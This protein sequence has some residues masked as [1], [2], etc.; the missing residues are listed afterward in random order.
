MDGCVRV[1]VSASNIRAKVKKFAPHF[2]LLNNLFD[3]ISRIR[4][5]NMDRKS[6]REC[7]V[8]AVLSYYVL[9]LSGLDS[10]N[11]DSYIVNKPSINIADTLV[12]CVG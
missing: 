3:E 10:I 12:L 1:R 6:E 11:F 5:D 4:W 2:H 8:E 9:L 7:K